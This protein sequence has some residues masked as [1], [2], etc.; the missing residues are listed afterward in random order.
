MAGETASRMVDGSAG[1]ICG[2]ADGTVDGKRRGG[3]LG[4]VVGEAL[5]RQVGGWNGCKVRLRKMM[6]G[7]GAE[8][9]ARCKPMSGCAV[10][11]LLGR[12][13]GRRL[14]F[15]IGKTHI[16]REVARPVSKPIEKQG[17]SREVTD[18]T[19]AGVNHRIL[20][21]LSSPSSRVVS[22]VDSTESEAA[23]LLVSGLEREWVGQLDRTASANFYS[24]IIFFYKEVS[25]NKEFLFFLRNFFP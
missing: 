2:C 11:F 6:D 23:E 24:L 17:L 9:W 25:L 16:D 12:H 1:L 8:R 13:S 10:G 19:N 4:V 3:I 18:A 20:T 15:G 22:L 5:G 21:L 7:I 14:G